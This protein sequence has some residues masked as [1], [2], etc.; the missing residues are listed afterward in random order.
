MLVQPGYYSLV[1]YC[2]DPSRLEA[3]N[4]G[5][6]LF[7]PSLNYLD[8][9]LAANNDRVARVFRN[10]QFRPW[11]LDSAK[12][13]L[14]DRLRSESYRPRTIEDFQLFIDTRGNEVVLTPL[15]PIKVSQPTGDLEGLFLDLVQEPR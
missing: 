1:Q 12:E 13:A 6:V 14:A 7:C 4:V 3:V 2:P 10:R 9:R 8:L 5:V 15:R 11:V